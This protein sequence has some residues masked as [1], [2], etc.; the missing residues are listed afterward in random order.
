MVIPIRTGRALR[1]DP[2]KTVLDSLEAFVELVDALHA[3]Q[4]IGK[5]AKQLHDGPPVPYSANKTTG[6]LLPD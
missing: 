4:L 1:L 5:P 3:A 6:H 2:F